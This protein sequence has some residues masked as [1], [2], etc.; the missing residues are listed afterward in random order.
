LI[1]QRS[2]FFR[3]ARSPQWKEPGKPS[4]LVDDNPAVFSLYL[5]CLYFGTS[6]LE[7]R[8]EANVVEEWDDEENGTLEDNADTKRC[9]MTESYIRLYVLAD[10]LL[11]PTTCEFGH[12]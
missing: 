11:D 6:E 9:I 2:E 5:H 8:I 4:R 10:K 3:A 12:R 7:K 1:T